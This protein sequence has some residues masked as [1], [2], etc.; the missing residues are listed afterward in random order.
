MEHTY[1]DEES[2]SVPIGVAAQMLGVSVDTLR[3]WSDG[4][5]IEHTRTLGGQRR[6]SLAEIERVKTRL[7]TEATGS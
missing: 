6:Y 5:A 1:T 3:R 7:R 2:Q 4:H